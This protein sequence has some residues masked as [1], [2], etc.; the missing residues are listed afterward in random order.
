MSYHPR[1]G[2]G[3]SAW[4]HDEEW[5]SF[6]M[7]QSSHARCDVPNWEMIGADYSR[8]PAKPV[9]DDEP[10]YE[11]HPI[12]PWPTWN[13]ANGYFRDHDVRQQCYRSVFAG[14]C[15]VSYGHQ[16]IWQFCGA[17]YPAINHADRPWQ[18]ALDRPGA[19]QM[20]HLRRLM[21]SRPYFSRIPD[22]SLLAANSE[23]RGTHMRATRDAAGNYALVYT[24]LAQP[25]HVRLEWAT[26]SQVRAWWYNPRSGGATV[27]GTFAAQG[28][29]A[30][31]PPV[32]GP[33]W[34]L[35]L[36]AVDAGFGTPGQ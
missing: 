7:W 10:N 2:L 24:P 16:A 20:I 23:E 13:P 11:D 35:V 6:N 8:L 28:T 31:Q 17:R 29:A 15:G 36:D 3:S 30:F 33:D 27:I 21:E 32:D 4:F 26:G 9:L 25:I 19:A 22:Q 5:L 1:G 34:V 14:G 12:S 18:E